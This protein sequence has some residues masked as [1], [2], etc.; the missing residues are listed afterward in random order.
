MKKLITLS[1]IL[2]FLFTSCDELDKYGEYGN[3]GQGGGYIFFAEG[4][5]Y[6]ECS[7][8]LGDTTWEAAIAN[9]KNHRGGG[10]S[11]WHLPT[12]N[13][14]DLVYKNLH[15][16]KLGGFSN[17]SYW[18]SETYVDYLNKDHAWGVWFSSGSQEHYS[19]TR[20]NGVRAVRSYTFE[21]QSATKLTIINQ[22]TKEISNVKW[23][24]VNFA[25]TNPNY[26]KNGE[27]VTKNVE[28]GGGFIF[29]KLGTISY[30]TYN[31]INVVNG[32][33]EVFTFT[34]NTYVIGENNNLP[35]TLGGL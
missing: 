25:G 7:G 12:R 4:G 14:L 16:N 20:S 26:I 5:Q 3:K 30:Q 32:S 17:G 19:Q 15:K 22:T 11:D 29:F 31:T 23:N 24:N 35:V 10:Y 28:A 33:N 8:E 27:T 1:L 34:N 9:A 6:M 21:P 2:V 13:E 18:T